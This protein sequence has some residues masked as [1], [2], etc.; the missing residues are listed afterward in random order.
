M[1]IWFLRRVLAFIIILGLIGSYGDNN[2][3]SQPLINYITPDAP[4]RLLVFLGLI[5]CVFRLVKSEPQKSQ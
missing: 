2:H 3:P 1:N 4:L 5:Y